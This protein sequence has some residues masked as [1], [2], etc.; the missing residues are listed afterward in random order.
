MSIHSDYVVHIA[1]ME[2]ISTRD[3]ERSLKPAT[4]TLAD[5]NRYG[6]STVE[7]YEEA[8]R[9]YVYGWTLAAYQRLFSLV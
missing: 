6:F 3:V 1:E 8:I 9:E 4:L 5:A 7:D 2:G